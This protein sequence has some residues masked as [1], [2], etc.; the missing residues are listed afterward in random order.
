MVV[1]RKP[2]AL[3]PISVIW[4]DPDVLDTWFSSGLWPFSTLGWPEPTPELARFY[5]GSVLVTAFDIIFFWVARMMMQGLHFMGE[6]PFKDV[7]IH[8]LVLDEKGQKMSKSKGNVVDPLE[9]IDTYG[10]DALRFTMAAM[11]AQGRNLRLSTQRIEGYRN[12]GTKLWNAARFGEMNGCQSGPDFD[13]KSCTQSVNQWIVSEAVIAA[14]DVTKFIE[15]YRFDAAADAAYKFAWGTYCDWY[16]ELIKPIMG[17]EDASAKAETQA[18]SSWALDQILKLLHPFMPFITEELW[19]NTAETRETDLI[20][21]EWP[22]L[23]DDLIN[24]EAADDINWL[25]RLVTA[26][27]SV[28]SEMNIPP[29]KKAPL[30][31]LADKADPRLT[32]FAEALERMARVE[33]IETASAAPQGALQTVV[34]GVSYAIPMEGLIDLGAEKARLTKEIEKTQSEIDK[35][36][37]K[38]G[39]EAFVSKAPEKVVT[40]QK[41][42]RAAYVEELDKLG[43][44]LAVLG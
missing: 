22:V 25:I 11:A 31:M 44:A 30:L 41:D 15:D 18:A 16:L 10:A 17:G 6:V 32:I 7:Y 8:A 9:L 20:L 4:R 42:R 12:F 35:I 33:G 1:M 19:A 39:N 34:D 13:P 38:L 29:S 2:R 37:K 24:A 21:A 27:R 28:R 40:L 14:K 26:L 43:E 23:G 36:D 5:P 3:Q